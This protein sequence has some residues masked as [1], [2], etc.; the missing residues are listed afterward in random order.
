MDR[1]EL[2]LVVGA[3]ED[4][5]VLDLDGDNQGS[6]CARRGQGTGRPCCDQGIGWPRRG[7]GGDQPR[8]G[9]GHARSNLGVVWDMY[10]A[11]L[12]VVR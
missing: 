7:Q 12:N 1:D 9:P 2:G 5:V 8:C 10:K 6:H 3:G 4:F 11:S